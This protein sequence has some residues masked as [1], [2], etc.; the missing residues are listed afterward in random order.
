MAGILN[1]PQ[2][3]AV[4]PRLC[5]PSGTA[6]DVWSFP[7]P[8]AAA[9]GPAPVEDP[10]ALPSG[11]QLGLP[12]RHVVTVPLWLQTADPALLRELIRAQFER[13]GMTGLAE[14]HWAY[15]VLVREENR[16][17]ASAFL[18][19]G[20]LPPG[21]LVPQVRGYEIAA[22]CRP[23]PAD[24]YA[25][26]AE[27]GGL[28]VGCTRGTEVAYLQF[29]PGRAALPE[30]AAELECLRRWL[31]WERVMADG[32]PVVFLPSGVPFVPQ[33]PAA[34]FGLVPAAIDQARKRDRQ[35]QQ[36]RRLLRNVAF[37]YGVLLLAVAGGLG[38]L[39]WRER[40]LE[41]KIAA[42]APAVTGLSETAARWRDLRP[43]IDPKL[44]PMECLLACV[45]ALP[46]EVRLTEF[47]HNPD[48]V[49]IKGEGRDAASIFKF[50]DAVKA[51][52]E[53]KQWTWT[54]PQPQLL[55]NNRAQFELEGTHGAAKAH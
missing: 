50:L 7:A 52:P 28:A 21:L 26:W 42:S 49:L 5:L 44:Y 20:A 35:A 45:A 46:P 4:I 51:D 10:A 33:L 13:R 18:I 34:P 41:K 39:K 31:S 54:L 11:S 23:L 19:N 32:A 12:A 6:W 2:R 36:R 47:D 22:R 25:V 16:T 37:A 15:A 1:L 53:L 29:F 43:A 24:T 14:S 8:E 38:V 55:P 48:N 9:Q 27:D 3:R 17:L 30:I 40:Q